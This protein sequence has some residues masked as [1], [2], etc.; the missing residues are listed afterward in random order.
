MRA[1]PNRGFS[2]L[3]FLVLLCAGSVWAQSPAPA[4]AAAPAAT[5]VAPAPNAEPSE[6]AAAPSPRDAA[7]PASPAATPPAPATAQPAAPAAPSTLTVAESPYGN[8]TRPAQPAAAQPVPSPPSDDTDDAPATLLDS[9]ADYALGGFGGFGVFYTRF[10]N[11]NAVE[12]CGEGGIIIDHALTLG[13]GGCGVAR[14]LK[15]EQYGPAPHDPDDRLSFGFG[16]A[17]ARYHFLSR[18]VVNVGLGALI[19]AGALQIGTWDGTGEDW[20]KDYEHKRSDAVFVFEPQVGAYANITRWL[21]V[22]ATASY[23]VVGGVNTKGLSNRSVRGP[24]LGGQIQ[25]GWF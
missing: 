10:A 15:A 16:G 5:T 23:R 18:K 21:R 24:T 20:E 14:E 17:I 22:G 25:G 9:S 13:G 6:A 2:T 1:L 12:L 3:P 7:A 8:G 19:G 4:P 11:K